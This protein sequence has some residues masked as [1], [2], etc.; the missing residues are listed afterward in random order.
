MVNKVPNFVKVAIIFW[1][2][3]GFSYIERTP[4][5]HRSH[6]FTGHLYN[7]KIIVNEKRLPK[8]YDL[9]VPGGE[10]FQP[11]LYYIVCSLINT[12]QI[13]VNP[14][15]H[16]DSIRI[17]SLIFGAITIFLIG[18]LLVKFSSYSFG[19]LLVLC[20][21]CSTPK[22]MFI[23]STYNNDSLITTLG[24]AIITFSYELLNGWEKEKG[25]LLFIASI[26]ALYT[27][28][29]IIPFIFIIIIFC[30]FFIFKTK[31]FNGNEIKIITVLLVSI[32]TLI[33]WLYFHNYKLTG[34]FFPNTNEENTTPI[35][36]SSFKKLLGVSLKIPSLIDVHP[37][38]SHEWD[39]PWAY[40]AW[41]NIPKETKRYDFLGYVF[42]TSLIGEYVFTAPEVNFIWLI[43]YINLILLMLSIYLGFNNKISRFILIFIGSYLFEY[44][45]LLTPLKSSFMHPDF[46]YIAWIW[47]PLSV[48]YV[49]S[50]NLANENVK[51]VF[52][53]CLLL[54]IVVNFYI[55][56][57]IE[58][59]YW[60]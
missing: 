45:L 18:K 20:F 22:F 15:N 28:F 27:K 13:N 33:P 6:D 1:L 51:K 60:W 3:I 17:L 50:I 48:L 42:I 36:F 7:T 46:R 55:L 43:I 11:P 9:A 26:A 39:K 52:L 56:Q 16:V 37:D 24:I 32:L 57:T 54:G 53:S 29:T 12:K 8:P 49:N 34:K 44:L 30:L 47:A 38:Y 14:K 35:N 59:G 40:P 31:Q 19:N 5:D 21:L 2:I 10:S 41:Q 23:F 4:Q 58:G 25:T